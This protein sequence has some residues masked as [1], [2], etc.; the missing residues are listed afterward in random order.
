M[1]ACW[2]RL[3]TERS[4]SPTRPS[5]PFQSTVLAC[6]PHRALIEEQLRLKRNFMAIYQ[7]FGDFWPRV[8]APTEN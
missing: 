7:D 5:A 1:R 8:L 6:E 3:A 2:Q 4:Y